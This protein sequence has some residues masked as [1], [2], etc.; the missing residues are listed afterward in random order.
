M[1]STSH[2]KFQCAAACFNRWCLSITAPNACTPLPAP[3]G[4]T[5]S[6]CKDCVSEVGMCSAGERKRGAGIAQSTAHGDNE[7]A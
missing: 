6:H 2:S 3:T 4:L 1:K 5:G 7:W